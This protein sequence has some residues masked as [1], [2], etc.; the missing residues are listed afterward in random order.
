LLIVRATS[1]WHEK[2]TEHTHRLLAAISGTV[3]TITPE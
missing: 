2:S 1:P 3:S